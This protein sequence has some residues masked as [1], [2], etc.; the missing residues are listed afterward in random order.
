MASQAPTM[1]FKRGNDLTHYFQLPVDSWV[2]GGLLWFTAKPA[3]DNDNTDANAVIN[4]S[5]DDSKVITSDDSEYLADYVTY[6]L[7]FAPSDV[8]NVSFSDGAKKNEYLGEFTIVS[9]LGTEETYPG[10]DNY[11]KTIIY[12]DIKRAA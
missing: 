10:D 5:F 3:V 8:T 12:A 6:R 2:P 4:K 9:A 11:I 1:E 7:E